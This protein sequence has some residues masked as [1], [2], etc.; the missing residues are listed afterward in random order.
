M[1]ALWYEFVCRVIRIYSVLQILNVQI[2]DSMTMDE[3]TQSASGFTDCVYSHCAL[4]FSWRS[5]IEPCGCSCIRCVTTR[6]Q[7][8]T[9]WSIQRARTQLYA[10]ASSTCYWRSTWTPAPSESTLCIFSWLLNSDWSCPD[11][12]AVMLWWLQ[13]L[14]CST[15]TGITSTQLR[16][17]RRAAQVNGILDSEYLL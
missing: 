9:V 6:R 5:M 2:H 4:T 7:R 3:L 8:P 16:W 1:I 15:R 12:G 17:V 10:H 13:P 11:S 14:T